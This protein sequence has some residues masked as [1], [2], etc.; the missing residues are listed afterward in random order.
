MRTE[1]NSAIVARMFRKS[2]Q[3]AFYPLLLALAWLTYFLL[4]PRFATDNLFSLVAGI[5]TAAI[6]IIHVLERAFPYRDEWNISRG[7]RLSNLVQTN[8]MLPA[9]SKLT[10]IFL[11]WMALHLV[12]PASWQ[13]LTNLWPRQA[14]VFAQLILALLICEFLFYWVHRLGHR[15]ETLW[16]FHRAHHTVKRVYWENSGR[17]HPLDLFFNW[18]FYFLP[19]VAFRVPADVLALFLLTNGVTGLLEHANVN[20]RGGFLN[21]IFNT[22]ELHRWHHSVVVEES[23]TNFGKVLCVWDQVFGS[24]YLPEDRAVGETGVI[25]E[26][27]H[28][29]NYW[30]ELAHPFRQLT[31]SLKSLFVAILAA[32]AFMRVKPATAS[33][34]AVGKAS[35]PSY[36]GQTC[37]VDN[38][39]TFEP[40]VRIDSGEYK[41]KCV[42]PT[43]RRS[44]TLIDKQADGIWTVANFSHL[45]QFWI[46]EIPVDKIVGIQLQVEYFPIIKTPKIDIG[47]TEFRVVFE[48]GTVI[49]LRPQSP[50]QKTQELKELDGFIFSVE[51]IS[52]YGEQFNA[53]KGLRDQYRMAY[54]FT[55]LEQKYDWMIRQQHHQVRQYQ[56]NFSPTE[57]QAIVREAIARATERSIGKAYDTLRASCVTELFDIVDSVFGIQH[58]REP[59]NPNT[60]ARKFQRRGFMTPNA[61]FTLFNDDPIRLNE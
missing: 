6:V 23:S 54:R 33:P 29:Q 12:P 38:Q 53:F 41:G 34:L 17:F 19:L 49:R 16:R 51:N 27:V 26:H 32:A 14:P 22:A 15:T 55:S 56:M 36:I 13:S 37:V 18:F 5:S 30:H 59:F 45:N 21:R 52:P 61:T 47:H 44:V 20:Y 60:A 57:S 10:E 11:G 28:I 25:D 7:D 2:F 39:D 40:H 46:A 24:Y 9:L 35:V 4:R 31:P 48:K 3:Y 58:G 8:L 1:P 42:N 43:L 50:R